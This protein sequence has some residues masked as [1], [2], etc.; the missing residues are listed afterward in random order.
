M[1]KFGWRQT[2]VKFRNKLG[3][4]AKMKNT[5]S[6][7]DVC[8]LRENFSASPTRQNKYASKFQPEASWQSQ[9]LENDPAANCM[10][11]VVFYITFEHLF[12]HPTLTSTPTSQFNV[13]HP[14]RAFKR[15]SWV[16]KIGSPS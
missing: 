6:M 16:P 4:V 11:W 8:I 10:I 12:R 13:V 14:L 5:F 7:L 1:R 15:V 3:N 9:F 2:F